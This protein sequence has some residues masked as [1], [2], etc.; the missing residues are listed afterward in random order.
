MTSGE[1]GGLSKPVPQFVTWSQGHNFRGSL[2][3]SLSPE[4]GLAHIGS[5]GTPGKQRESWP[6]QGGHPHAGL[7]W[8]PGV[9]WTLREE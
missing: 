4:Q 5:H 3:L 9:L 1:S 7:S 6:D 8:I 2:H